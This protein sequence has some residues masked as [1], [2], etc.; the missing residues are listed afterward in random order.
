MKF[1]ELVR[2][3]GIGRKQVAFSTSNVPSPLFEAETALNS[4]ENTNPYIDASVSVSAFA[5]VA[6]YSAAIATQNDVQNFV[7][8]MD[9]L[10]D[11]AF[12]GVPAR[13]QF[14]RQIITNPYITYDPR[15]QFFTCRK[16]GFYLVKMFVNYT[17]V[18]G[19]YDW[20]ISLVPE[21]NQVSN[22]TFERVAEYMDY[23]NVYKHCQ[24]NGTALFNV[25][26][27]TDGGRQ[28]ERRF[29]INIGTS[30]TGLNTFTN[31]NTKLSLQIIYLGA[32]AMSERVTYIE[33]RE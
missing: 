10:T 27:Q 28:G 18:N 24:L 21:S 26:T 6:A 13:F 30:H 29:S 14:N 8:E 2:P 4:A 9:T 16:P 11:F 7:F 15:T 22:Y 20:Y 33:Y 1:N 3:A 17:G 19:N 5:E 12:V 23:H 32:L 25:P 31:S